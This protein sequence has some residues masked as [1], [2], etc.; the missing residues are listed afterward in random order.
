[1]NIDLDEMSK[2]FCF[3]GG[4]YRFP[5]PPVS[6]REMKI[7]KLEQDIVRLSGE[8]ERSKEWLEA[9]DRCTNARS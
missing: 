3:Q 5:R 2:M 1:M 6:S 8:I 9:V 7:A 4:L